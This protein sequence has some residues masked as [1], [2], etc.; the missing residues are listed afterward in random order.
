M[1]LNLHE[2]PDWAWQTAKTVATLV[3]AYFAGHIING[4]VV[5]RIMRLTKHTRGHWEAAVVG[6]IK[7]RVPWLALLGGA[8]LSL[9]YWSLGPY[10]RA[11]TSGASLR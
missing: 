1:S 9:G 3:I 7:R 5:A 8:W 2:W 6:E 10:L 11:F 4:V